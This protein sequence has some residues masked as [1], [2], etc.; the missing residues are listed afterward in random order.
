MCEAE[1]GVHRNVDVGGGEWGEEEGVVKMVQKV[2]SLTVSL[3][4]SGGGDGWSSLRRAKS[5]AEVV[6]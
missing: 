2:F 1:F 3:V 5:W 6:W 4:E